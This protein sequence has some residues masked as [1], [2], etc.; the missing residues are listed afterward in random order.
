MNPVT[1]ATK[2]HFLATVKEE[3]NNALTMFISA[4]HVSVAGV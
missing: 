1:K 2:V 3:L 4:F